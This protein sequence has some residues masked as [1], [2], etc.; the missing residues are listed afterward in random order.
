[1]NVAE[2]SCSTCMNQT[3]SLF[4][5]LN[6]EIRN[7]IYELVVGG[8]TINWRFGP[9]T[10]SFRH[11]KSRCFVGYVYSQAGYLP[12]SSLVSL[13]AV[14]RQT[15]PEAYLLPF[16]LNVVRGLSCRYSQAYNNAERNSAGF[17]RHLEDVNRRKDLAPR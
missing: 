4:L 8:M 13:L 7:Y 2:I 5:R 3:N 9:P 15:H 17:N 12:L 10:A 1:M 6:R 11:S 14:C 16:T